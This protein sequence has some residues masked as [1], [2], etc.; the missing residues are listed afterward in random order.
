[1][2][3]TGVFVCWC[4]SNIAKTVDVERVAAE[5]GDLPGVVH[6]AHYKYMCSEPGQ[7]LVRQAIAEHRLDRIVVAACSPRLHEPTFRKCIAQTGLNPFMA[8]MA[9][10]REHCSW[11]HAD[12][13]TATAKAID[14]TRMAAAR[15]RRNEPLSQTE[16][17]ITK[18][19]LVVGGGIAGIQ[20]AL[21]IAEAGYQVTLVERTPSIGGRMAQFD[22]TFPTLDCAACILTPKMVECASNPNIRIVSYAEVEEVSGY[23]GN[24]EV[25]IRRRARGVDMEKCT[26]CGVCYEKCPVKVS[27]EF[28]AGMGKRKAIYVPFPQ[29]VPNVPVIDREHCTYYL[30]G[31]CR[32]CEKFCQP[33]AVNFEQQDEILA[34]TF[35][36]IVMAT[37]FDVWDQSAVGEYGGGQIPD[38]ISGLQFER[39][40]NASG[41]TGGK[42]LR[43]SDHKEPKTVVFVACVGSRDPAHGHPYCSKVCCMYTAKHALLLKE[44]VPD[45]KAYIF[46]MDIRANGKGYEEFVQRVVERYDATYVRGRVSRIYPLDG[47]L[48]VMGADTLLGKPVEVHA[49]MVVLAAAMEPR[50]DAKEMARKLGLSTDQDN[51]FSEAHPKLRPVEVLTSGVYLAGA[52]QYPKDIPDTVAQASGAAA[53]VVD[54]FSKPHLLSEPMIACVDEQNCVACLLCK[55]VCPFSAIEAAEAIDPATRKPRATAR[56]NSGLCHGCGTCVAA[57]RSASIRLFGFSDDQI[58]LQLDSLALAHEE[59]K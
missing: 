8:E 44:K 7:A 5:A 43:P 31:R 56:V 29:A 27:A 33:G 57:C 59:T 21:D 24:F 4:G 48:V 42:V 1:M 49:D 47:H 41:P 12:R 45:A 23:V 58:L 46:Y 14:L 22:K 19:A 54:L 20:A 18:K 52:C 35:G 16:I 17:P 37:G 51:W 25:K 3:R 28:D 34:E 11:V 30:K 39:L 53:K 32:L 15:I 2:A 26:G 40:V 36:A 6:A 38:V 10:I 50:A 55:E 9:N 13:E